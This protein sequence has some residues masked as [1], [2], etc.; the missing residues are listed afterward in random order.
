MRHGKRPA[1]SR[2]TLA[3]LML[4][5]VVC[6][7]TRAFSGDSGGGQADEQLRQSHREVSFL[8][9]YV[10]GS[11]CMFYRNGSWYDS[12]QALAHL[13]EKYDWLAARREIASAEDFI[14]KVATRSRLTG[15]AY[16]VRCP[17][18]VIVATAPWLRAELQWLRGH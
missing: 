10:A 2:L 16:A 4:A 12:V 14:D 1:G 6:R 8:L 5:A 3:T 17:D 11:A 13:R 15:E 7:G 18:G 9:G